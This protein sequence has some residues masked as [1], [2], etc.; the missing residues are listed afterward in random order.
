MMIKLLETVVLKKDIPEHRLKTGGLGTVVERYEPDGIEV[1]F[2]MGNG[3][4]RVLL[5]LK[6]HT[7]RALS[8][9]DVFSVRSEDAA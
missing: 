3:M 6:K 2:I 4:A 1:E 7:V 8:E 5:T 9:S